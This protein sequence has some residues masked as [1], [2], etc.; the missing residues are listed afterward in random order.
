MLDNSSMPTKLF[1]ASRRKAKGN[2]MN[3]T[4]KIIKAESE[5]STGRIVTVWHV[6]DTT[7]GFVCD[8]FDLKRD[9]VAWVAA[10]TN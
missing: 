10:S 2:K 7:D 4:Y 1:L 3:V 5:T 8:A 6:I 9:A